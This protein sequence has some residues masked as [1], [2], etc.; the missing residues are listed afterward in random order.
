M[1]FLALNAEGTRLDRADFPRVG[2]FGPRRVFRTL[3][4]KVLPA[5]EASFRTRNGLAPDADLDAVMGDAAY[6]YVW[7]ACLYVSDVTDD[8]IVEPGGDLG[9]VFLARTGRTG[10]RDELRR[11]YGRKDIDKVKPGEVL[12]GAFATGAVRFRSAP[13]TSDFANQVRDYSKAFDAFSRTAAREISET[14]AK[15]AGGEILLA[16]A[17][18]DGAASYSPPP[19]CPASA[20][21]PV[22]VVRLKSAIATLGDV[23]KNNSVS[24]WVL[25][26][27]F[28]AAR[29]EPDGIR[30]EPRFPARRFSVEDLPDGT[31]TI[32][33]RIRTSDA[34]PDLDAI[35]I[36]AAGTPWY[37]SG[38]GTHVAGTII[39][40]A[41]LDDPAFFDLQPDDSWLRLTIVP[42]SA[43]GRE[44]SSMALRAATSKV[45]L[46][47]A[48]VAN[49]SVRYDSDV[50]AALVAAIDR[51][52]STLF[53]AAAG[54]D[55]SDVIATRQ[56]QRTV[57]PARLG[58]DTANVISVAAEDGRGYLT[59]FTNRSAEHVDIAAPGC[60]IP[61]WIADERIERL[62][63]TSQAAPLVT[64]AASL[65]SRYRL[66]AR[67]IKRRI[68]LSGDLLAGSLELQ[69]ESFAAVVA[70]D[71]SDIPIY[72]RSRLNVAKALLFRSDYLRATVGVEGSLDN[73]RRTVELLGILHTQ[74][75]LRCGSRDVDTRMILALKR[76]LAFGLWCFSNGR[77]SPTRV[78]PG[79]TPEIEFT[80]V[81]P[82]SPSVAPHLAR[83][84]GPPSSYRWRICRSSSAPMPA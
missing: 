71:A 32:G 26:N 25:D 73:P 8:A 44:V 72:S 5:Y 7:P 35:V 41:T 58:G 83:R 53:V 70:D 34:G 57:F 78:R 79:G 16:A 68:L 81:R 46:A 50:S 51:N 6:G 3:C 56:E 42:L 48:S 39:G 10:G 14:I 82:F 65:L 45:D 66:D 69:G 63:G 17:E 38:H 19:D 13:G 12:N 74:G 64:F 15:D 20:P 37:V 1:R 77:R 27:G 59:K 11:F 23:Q 62:S 84:P 21:P 4:G 76:S 43:G 29:L 80:V 18:D 36:P 33:P 61:S 40:S 55:G 54:N 31:P 52:P 24:V 28:T 60:G 22:D 30:F 2:E 9:S 49:L 47:K 67:R 75:D